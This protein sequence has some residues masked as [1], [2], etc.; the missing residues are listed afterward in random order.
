MVTTESHMIV[1][2]DKRIAV[3]RLQNPASTWFSSE[4]LLVLTSNTDS[5]QRQMEDRWV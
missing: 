1:S 5:Q 4:C 2:N 3:V